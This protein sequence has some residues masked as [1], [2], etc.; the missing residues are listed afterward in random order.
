MYPEVG[1]GTL[2]EARVWVTELPVQSPEGSLT[3][4]DLSGLDQLAYWLMWK[5]CWTE[6]N[7]SCTIYLKPHEWVAATAFVSTVWEAVGGLAFLPHSDHVYTLAPYEEIDAVTYEARLALLPEELGLADIREQVDTP[8][9]A[10]DCACVGG[11][12]EI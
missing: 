11:V 10:Q 8:T 2:A 12:C 1:Q 9:V 5:T 3:R 6:H 7:P 4:H